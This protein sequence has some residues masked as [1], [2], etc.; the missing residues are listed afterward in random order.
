MQHYF[1]SEGARSQ[2]LV[3]LV[4]YVAAAG[5]HFGCYSIDPPLHIERSVAHCYLHTAAVHSCDKRGLSSP[6][7]EETEGFPAQLWMDEGSRECMY[8]HTPCS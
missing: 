1:E 4:V 6:S 2:R 8:V 7:I 5:R 3:G